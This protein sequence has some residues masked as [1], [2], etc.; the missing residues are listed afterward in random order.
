MRS[1]RRGVSATSA[2]G[3]RRRSFLETLEGDKMK[4]MTAFMTPGVF[5]RFGLPQRLP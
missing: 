1:I 2:R 3:H 5:H 4:E